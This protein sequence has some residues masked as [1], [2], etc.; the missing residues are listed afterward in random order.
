MPEHES[1]YDFLTG[2]QFVELGAR[3][4]GVEDVARRLE[5][6]DRDRRP[7][8]S[9]RTGSSAATR[10]GCG[11]GCGSPRRSCTTRRCCCWTSRSPGPIPRSGCTCATSSGRLAAEGR[12]ILVSS[13]I[14]EEVDE[15]ADRIH[16]MV[17][18]K[19]AAS[20]DFRA[21]RQKL[22]R[23]AVRRPRRLRRPAGARRGP[24]PRSRPSSRSRSTG[25]TGSC[26]CAAETSRRSSARFPRSRRDSG[27]PPHAGRAARRLARER[28]RVPGVRERAMSADLRASPSASS[29]A[30]GGSGSCSASSACRCS[31]RSLFR[32]A[33]LDDHERAS[34]PT[35]SRGRSSPRR[36]CRS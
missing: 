20:G 33:R 7:R 2:R 31:R 25:T 30:A 27:R 1:V 16:L 32:V 24:R 9:T 21:I 11:S 23:P 19:L 26:A 22:E 6:G 29:P 3:L 12:T 14:L 4:Q 36:S 5:P 34:S 18:G 28:L 13:H 17:S 15:L 35:T 8:R 10:A